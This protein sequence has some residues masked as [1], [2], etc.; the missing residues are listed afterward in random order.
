[1]TDYKALYEETVEENKKL[2]EEIVSRKS[3]CD[4]FEMLNKE[5][6][7]ELQKVKKKYMKTITKAAKQ[8]K[9][10][11]TKLEDACELL[12]NL[13]YTVDDDGT[14]YEK[15]E[16]VEEEVDTCIKCNKKRECLSDMFITHDE[17]FSGGEKYM[18]CGMC[19]L[20]H[21]KGKI[22]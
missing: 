6:Y 11:K 5:H 2:K 21:F 7:D 17:T 14:W 1:M 15:D 18:M 20:T 4:H 16:C 22:S 13:D 3:L 9:E 12:N 10:L 19:S 8:K